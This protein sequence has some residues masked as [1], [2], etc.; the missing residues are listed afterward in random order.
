MHTSN[1]KENWTDYFAQ[2]MPYAYTV[3]QLNGTL[4]TDNF[5]CRGRYRAIELA[6][7]AASELA[8]RMD[9][10]FFGERFVQQKVS[11]TDRFNAIV[12]VEKAGVSTHL[13]ILWYQPVFEVLERDAVFRLFAPALYSQNSN[14]E[15]L[16]RFM[17][18]TRQP[19][20]AYEQLF[21]ERYRFH[22]FEEQSSAIESKIAPWSVHTQLIQP[23]DEDIRRVCSYVTKES[24]ID[25]DF[26]DL[27][28]ELSDFHKLD[29]RTEPTRCWSYAD[30]SRDVAILDLSRGLTADRRRPIKL[31]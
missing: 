26:G 4:N 23:T 24:E 10:A 9:Q 27:V 31:R 8:F 17:N 2:K 21:L 25:H 16:L 12:T 7:S 29:Q 28:F 6:K 22:A 19:L 15:F 3:V 20:S 5:G 18:N 13:N 30:D 14:A 11:G 1:L